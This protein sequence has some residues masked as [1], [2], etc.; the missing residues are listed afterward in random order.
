MLLSIIII[1]YKT[2]QLTINCVKSIL[3]HNNLGEKEII[4]IDNN[5]NN[6]SVHILRSAFADKVKIIEN[7]ENKGFSFA[8]NQ[9]AKI[10]SGNF[11]LFLNSDTIVNDDIFNSAI[12]IFKNYKDVAIISPRLELEN[13]SYQ[14]YAYGKAIT[15]WRLV[16][17]KTKK[18]IKIKESEKL[19]EID[20]VSGCALFIKKEVFKKINGFDE[21]FFLYFEDVDI[22]K[23]VK[24]IGFKV[25][26]DNSVRVIH[27]VGK[28]IDQ[29]TTRKKYYYKSQNYY[30][31]KN[32]NELVSLGVRILR[33]LLN[34]K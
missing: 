6:N 5:S 23:K 18:E 32:H 31:K 29:H 27:L 10:A 7:K 14:K 12:N 9:G 1:N 8:N 16:S 30:F 22:C 4:I 2:P 28:S 24:D 34:Y 21:N 26:I 33:I 25:V 17:R 19:F 13:G 11:L 20:W 3:S 15:P